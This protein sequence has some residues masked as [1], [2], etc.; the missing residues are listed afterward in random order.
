MF[1]NEVFGE[2]CSVEALKSFAKM[3]SAI[4]RKKVDHLNSKYFI[5][6]YNSFKTFNKCEE[7]YKIRILYSIY[8]ASS[9]LQGIQLKAS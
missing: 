8:Q 1:K 2:N 7:N 6:N 3:T 4:K 5:S 9:R